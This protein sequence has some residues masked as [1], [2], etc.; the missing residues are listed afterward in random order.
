MAISL[1]KPIMLDMKK[2]GKFLPA[3]VFKARALALADFKHLGSAD[4]AHTLSSWPS[5]LHSDGLRIFHLLLGFALH[6]ISFHRS[7]PFKSAE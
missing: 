4:G 7:P 2:A 5:I 6:A 1:Q 3:F